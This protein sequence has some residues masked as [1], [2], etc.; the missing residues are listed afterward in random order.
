MDTS[1]GYYIEI[2]YDMIPWKR[3]YHFYKNKK[4][5]NSIDW[6]FKYII[7]I[8]YDLNLALHKLLIVC[9]TCYLSI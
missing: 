8:I 5:S 9:I 7:L 4:N 3:Q 2:N 1:L 6:K